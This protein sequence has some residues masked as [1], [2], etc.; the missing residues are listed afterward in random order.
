M[1]LP[2]LGGE[3]KSGLAQSIG[4]PRSSAREKSAAYGATSPVTSH[5]TLTT[6]SPSRMTLV[7]Q[8]KRKSAVS[9]LASPTPV[10]SR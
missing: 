8:H 6:P 4:R 2:G 5:A 1:A 10:P 9:T 3:T 7:P